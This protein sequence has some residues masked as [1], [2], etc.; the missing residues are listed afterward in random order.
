MIHTQVIPKQASTTNSEVPK[1]DT[2]LGTEYYIDSP[3]QRKTAWCEK[4]YASASGRVSAFYSLTHH[5]PK[6]AFDGTI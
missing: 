1:S 5:L 6:Q 3:M 2:S 4:S